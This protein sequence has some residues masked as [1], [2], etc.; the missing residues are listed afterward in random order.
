LVND[1][2]KQRRGAAD[3]GED[4][5]KAPASRSA[6]TLTKYLKSYI[7]RFPRREMS[8]ARAGK[9]AANEAKYPFIVEVPIAAN[10][11]NVE[12]HARLGG[13]AADCGEYRQAAGAC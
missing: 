1:K 7:P 13:G 4:Y 6:F 8:F 12:N 3:R 11:L 2:C 9:T 10:G 5:P